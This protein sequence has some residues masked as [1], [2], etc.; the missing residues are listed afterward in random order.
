VSSLIQR[1]GGS[2]LVKVL[3]AIYGVGLVLLVVRALPKEAYGEYGIAIA[4]MNVAAGLSRGLWTM[5]LVIGAAKGERDSLLAPAFWYGL[6]TATLGGLLAMGVLPLL[7][8]SESLAVITALMLLVLVPR[9]LALALSQAQGRVW[10]AFVI[11]AGYFVGSLAGFIALTFFRQLQT[12]EAVMLMN[13]VSA[14]LSMIIGLGFEPGILH[15]GKHGDWKGIF[16]IGRW[17]GMNALGEI[18][19]QQGDVLLIGMFFKPEVIAPYIAARTLLRMYTLLSQS[20]N[21]IVL[22]SA[23]RLGA[24]NQL[25]L[26]RKRLRTLFKYMWAFLLV[27]NG[28]M[29][30]ACPYI[31]PRLLGPAYAASIPFF[32]LMILATFLEPVYSILA[33]AIAGIGKPKLIVFVLITALGFN[34]VADLVSLSLSHNIKVAPV[35]LVLTYFVLAY[36]MWRLARK[37]FVDHPTAATPASQSR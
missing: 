36:G 31:F 16:H 35:V 1:A 18:F 17:I 24:K 23:S 15:P 34:I 29:W 25:L 3:P 7:H 13:L 22:P 5:P 6:G 26:L 14:V 27:F 8:V 10:V 37:H 32:R 28:I 2:L 9:E 11:E 12:A 33:N 20:V 21:F 19:L 30:F 4:F